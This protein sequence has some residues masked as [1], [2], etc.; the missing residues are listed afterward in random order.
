MKCLVDSEHQLHYYPK[1]EIYHPLCGAKSLWGTNLKKHIECKECV[2]MLDKQDNTW[3]YFDFK[4]SGATKCGVKSPKLGTN[5]VKNVTCVKCKK[6]I[7]PKENMEKVVHLTVSGFNGKDPDYIKCMNR[8]PNEKGDGSTFTLSLVTCKECI[9]SL[10]RGTN[11][12]YCF[13][14]LSGHE[15]SKK[16]CYQVRCQIKEKIFQYEKIKKELKELFENEAK[17]K[18]AITESGADSTNVSSGPKTGR[19]AL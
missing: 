17:I 7:V 13:R 1:D 2:M 3:H 19:S 6:F 12:R 14:A 5:F 15:V 8:W 18:K 9:K 16:H 10:G 4:G 11:C